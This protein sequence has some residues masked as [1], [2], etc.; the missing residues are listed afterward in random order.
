MKRG[1]T[2]AG[3]LALALLAAPGGAAGAGPVAPYDGTNP[4]DCQLQQAG[5]GVEFPDPDA[6]PFCVEYDKTH[7]NVSQGGVVDFLSNEPRRVAVASDKC[8][9]FQH[10]HWRGSVVQESQQTETYNWDGSY[11][12]DRA[13]GVG[14]AYVENFTVNNQTMDPR[15]FPGFPEEYKPYFGPGKGGVQRAGDVPGDPHCVEKAARKSPLRQPEG[16]P[17]RCQD[18]R[19]SVGRGI[20]G[21]RLGMTRREVEAALGAAPRGLRGFLRYCLMDGGKLAIGFPGGRGARAE[22]VLTTSAAFDAGGVRPGAP[23]REARRR[24]SG[25]RL[26]ARRGA[27]TVLA[28]PGRGRTLLVGLLRGTVHYLAVADPDLS[29]R[30]IAR[31][32]TRSR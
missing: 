15:T 31:Y 23:A 26:L 24:L 18:R 19:G 4:F 32:L 28:V 13:R 20:G 7:Q 11:F 10:D 27:F 3:C 16:P 30:Q 12:F 8:F 1:A 14:G 2:T 6:D 17:D 29:A 25:E 9:Y 5:L 22:L 21:A